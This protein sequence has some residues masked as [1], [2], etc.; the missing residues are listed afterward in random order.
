MLLSS[1]EVGLEVLLSS[2]DSEPQEVLLSSMEMELEVLLSSGDSEL[3]GGVAKQHGN[4]ARGV[5]KQQGQ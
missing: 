4:A 1:V 3:Q 5:A 2:V